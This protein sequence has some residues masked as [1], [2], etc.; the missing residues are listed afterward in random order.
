MPRLFVFDDLHGLFL[1]PRAFEC[2]HIVS[3][4][5]GGLYTGEP[6]LSATRFA[7]R[8]AHQPQ[9]RTYLIRSHSNNPNLC[10][11]ILDRLKSVGISK[12]HI[13]TRNC[14][15]RELAAATLETAF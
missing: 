11:L 3:W 9:P 5:I 10:L 4:L 15:K 2:A 13:A 8:Q 14:S 1:A 7:K 12:I 6:H